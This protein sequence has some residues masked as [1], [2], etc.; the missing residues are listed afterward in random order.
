MA[1]SCALCGKEAMHGQFIRHPHSGA[2]ATRAPR[3][4]RLFQPNLQAVRLPVN[5]V[6]KRTMVCTKCI[7]KG[8]AIQPA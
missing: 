8:R 6:N 4:K 5:G 3:K 7:K 2:W 1:K